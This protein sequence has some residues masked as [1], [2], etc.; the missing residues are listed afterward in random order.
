MNFK[1]LKPLNY[2]SN[3]Y[4]LKLKERERSTDYLRDAILVLPAF[5]TKIID[6]QEI[7]QLKRIIDLIQMPQFDKNLFVSNEEVCS[8]NL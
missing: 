6:I 4:R 5:P 8:S 3:C 2:N 7:L 1:Y